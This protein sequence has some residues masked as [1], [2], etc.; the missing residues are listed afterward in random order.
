MAVPHGNHYLFCVAELCVVCCGHSVGAYAL[1]CRCL[2]GSLW[3]LFL[4]LWSDLMPLACTPV[5]A[6]VAGSGCA[7]MLSHSLMS[8]VLCMSP[9]L[10]VGTTTSSVAQGAAGRQL[11]LL[12]AA[13]NQ[14]R[15]AN[16]LTTKTIS[17]GTIRHHSPQGGL[18]R[19]HTVHSQ[20]QRWWPSLG[21]IRPK[22]HS[23]LQPAFNVGT[24]I[25]P[26]GCN[27]GAHW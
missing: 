18:Q 12:A 1:C 11:L 22:W 26:F 9:T 23:D 6:Q 8:W 21:W 27:P 3:P 24:A 25:G 5:N 2:K 13:A 15:L 17:R 10:G 16:A 7:Q 14:Q 4:A 19:V 20:F